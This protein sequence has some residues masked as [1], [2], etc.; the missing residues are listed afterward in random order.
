MCAS[1]IAHVPTDTAHAAMM[2][3]PIAKA[4]RRKASAASL[5]PARLLRTQASAWSAPGSP[6]NARNALRARAPAGGAPQ[7]GLHERQPEE[8]VLHRRELDHFTK[9]MNVLTVVVLEGSMRIVDVRDASFLTHLMTM[10]VS[11]RRHKLA[12]LTAAG[13]LMQAMAA[14]A[15]TPHAAMGLGPAAA[16]RPASSPC[17]SSAARALSLRCPAAG[18][19]ASSMVFPGADDR[20][21][22]AQDRPKA[23]A[24]NLVGF[25]SLLTNKMA[26]E[27]GGGPAAVGGGVVGGGGLAGQDN[28][29]LRADGQVAGGPRV[30]GWEDSG[31]VWA[32]EQRAAGGLW[33]EYADGMGKR[34]LEVMLLL[35]PASAAAR[36]AAAESPGDRPALFYDGIVLE[37]SD[38]DFSKGSMLP[39]EK[40]SV[41]VVGTVATGPAGSAATDRTVVSKFSMLQLQL[42]TQKLY[43]TV[44]PFSR[45]FG[46]S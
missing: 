6:P 32:S 1:L 43:Q 24:A 37:M 17:L 30:P 10:A 14:S 16:R 41:R 28:L 42:D 35:P 38:F 40:T 4:L 39:S 34:R 21:E 33:R 9:F 5:V 36:A 26:L 27:D 23:A 12:M 2:V 18:C 7:H 25:W 19:C 46:R 29:V 44:I 20:E 13:T 15:Y 11:R 31:V 8:H 45:P 3:S 22:G